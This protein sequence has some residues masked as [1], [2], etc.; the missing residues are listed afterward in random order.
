M[1]GNLAH[2]AAEAIGADG[3]LAR[4]AAYYH[5][6]GKMNRPE[7]FVE[8]QGGADNIHDRLSPYMSA[9]V[10]T[11]HVKEGLEIAD[12]I[13]LPTRVRDLIEQHHG[14]TLMKYFHHRAVQEGASADD[15]LLEAQF[16]YAGP[17]PR[18]KEAAILMLADSV[19]AASRCLDKPTPA[20]I[21]DF[22]ARLVEDK[23]GDGQLDDCDLTLRELQS[24]QDVFARTL[25]GVLHARVV[26]PGDGASRRP[27]LP[28]AAAPPPPAAVSAAPVP[29][30]ATVPLAGGGALTMVSG[31]DDS[32]AI[33][34]EVVTTTH[35]DRD[36]EHTAGYPA[37][38][39][40]RPRGRGN[41]AAPRR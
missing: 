16:R 36:P 7:F 11:S 10:L 12:E 17:K 35:G 20:R 33:A 34:Q 22:V 6:V 30:E 32:P 23:R 28:A 19:E 13:G 40:P 14:T 9:L 4:V 37:D 21:R 25:S 3:L 8:N 1:V 38:D 41:A 15:P 5:D 31:G 2:A 26:Y 18:T 29:A 39:G 24:V 27:S